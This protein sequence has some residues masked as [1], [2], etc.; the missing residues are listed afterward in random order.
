M[1]DNL[2]CLSTQLKMRGSYKLHVCTIFGKYS[3]YNMLSFIEFMLLLCESDP[4][5]GM[6]LW[7]ERGWS[8]ADVITQITPYHDIR[9]AWKSFSSINIYKYSYWIT[10]IYY[11]TLHH[12]KTHCDPK[13]EIFNGSRQT[14]G[15]CWAN[16]VRLDFKAA[17]V[18]YSYSPAE[19]SIYSY[20]HIIFYID[21]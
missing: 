12:L 11:F 4:S 18:Q 8:P 20:F 2:T 6:V 14:F 7:S 3:V 10:M 13:L 1:R 21:R 17:Q 5:M 16:T 15:K 19:I 9:A